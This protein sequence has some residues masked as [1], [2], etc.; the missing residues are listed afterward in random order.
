LTAW[1]ALVEVAKVKRGEKVFVQA[2]SGGVDF[3]LELTRD[4]H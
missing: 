3:R 4:F 2:G 1:Q